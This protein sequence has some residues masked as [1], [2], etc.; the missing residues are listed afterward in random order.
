VS[1][2]NHLG[3]QNI[4]KV[5]W[6]T[7]SFRC[8]GSLG[9][10]LELKPTHYTVITRNAMPAGTEGN[11]QG[12]RVRATCATRPHPHPVWASGSCS[13]VTTIRGSART[14]PRRRCSM[15]HAH[16]TTG[17]RLFALFTWMRKRVSSPLLLG[18]ACFQTWAGYVVR[19]ARYRELVR[20]GSGVAAAAGAFFSEQML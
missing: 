13:A 16:A 19:A 17:L 2:A 18:F 11:L 15:A 5:C 4:R 1:H 6:N 7:Y 9:P 14:K 10:R 12:H 8:V 20:T 3:W